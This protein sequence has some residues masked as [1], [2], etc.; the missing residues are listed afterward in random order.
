[1]FSKNYIT[2][3]FWLKEDPCF[4]K[5]KLY[6]DSILVEGS[7]ILRLD[8]NSTTFYMEPENILVWALHMRQMSFSAY[9]T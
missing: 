3:V 4:Q 8:C 2:I 5:K 9:V 6:Y 1:M 7:L